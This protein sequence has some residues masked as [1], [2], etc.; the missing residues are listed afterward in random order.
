[1]GVKVKGIILNQVRNKGYEITSEEIEAIS[2]V[3][4]LHKIPYDE[5][6]VKSVAYKTPG[7]EQKPLSPASIAFYELASKITDREWEK[8]RFLRIKRIFA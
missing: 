3:E 2:G 8:P 1:M 6:L 7:I 4:V 5:N